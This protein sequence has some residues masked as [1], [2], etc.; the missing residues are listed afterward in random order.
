MNAADIMTTSVIT[1]TADTNVRDIAA[2][3]LSKRISAVPVIDENRKVLGIISEGD[4]MRRIENDT[5]EQH[6]WWIENLFS[7]SHDAEHYLKTHGRRAAELMSTDLITITEETPLHEIA[8]LL[9]TNHVKRVPVIRGDKL[10]G[11]VSRANLLQG[12]TAKGSVTATT[13]SADDRTIRESLLHEL[14]DE[15][16]IVQGRVNVTVSDGVVQLW[17]LVYSEAEKSAAEVAA[18]NTAGVRSVENFLGQLPP[19]M[20]EA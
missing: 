3:L 13:G 10:V 16:G 11:I 12:L 14:S 4:L 7:A 2:L 5:G 1:V 15:V 19:W 17:G 9:E 20:S 18:L 6:S 8:G